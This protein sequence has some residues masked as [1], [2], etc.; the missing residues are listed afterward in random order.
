M[1]SLENELQE[2]MDQVFEAASEIYNAMILRYVVSEADQALSPGGELY[3]TLLAGAIAGAAEWY[4]MYSPEVYQREYSMTAPNN[5]VISHS[6][7]VNGAQVTG[8]F[9]VANISPHAGFAEGFWFYKRGKPFYRP[10][11]DLM[12]DVP[13]S[14]S[15]TVNI[16][17]EIADAYFEQ[18]LRAVL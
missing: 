7:S 12:A 6:I 9:S 10:G 15:Y 3:E 16:P 1:A 5:I 4:G 17:Q 11:G 8:T 13:S 18:A 14:L 2:F